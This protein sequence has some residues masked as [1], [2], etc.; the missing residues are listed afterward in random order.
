MNFV[1]GA[2]DFYDYWD[3]DQ[4]MAENEKINSI[5]LV[6][7]TDLGHLD[8]NHMKNH[9]STDIEA[10]TKVELPLWLALPLSSSKIVDTEIPKYYGEQFKRSLR[11]E[12]MVLNLQEKSFY[13]YENGLVYAFL[14]NDLILSRILANAFMARFR[15]IIDRALYKSTEANEE[16]SSFVKKLSKL[17]KVIYFQGKRSV[18]EYAGWKNR[19]FEKMSVSEVLVKPK[20]RMRLTPA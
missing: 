9:S 7:A 5:F 17:E 1:R 12:P 6:N 18:N 20:K 8:A 11:A 2:E 4:I 19:E 10:N 15:A 16:L 14:F 13:Y 3:L